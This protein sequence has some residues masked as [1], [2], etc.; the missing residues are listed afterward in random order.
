MGKLTAKINQQKEEASK[1]IKSADAASVAAFAAVS[2]KVESVLEASAKKSN[3]K[4]NKLYTEMAAQR[5]KL[6][7]NLAGA[8]NDINDSIAKQAALADSR[9]AK[10]V[11][12]IKAARAEASKQVKDA[13]KSFATEHNSLTSTIKKM[14]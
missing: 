5:K 8:V 11:K 6:D 1:A 3:Q 7:E 9:F 2:D 14:D 4:F 12:S 10:T 13:R